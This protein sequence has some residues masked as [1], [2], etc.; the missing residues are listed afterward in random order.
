MERGADLSDIG[1]LITR[2]S[3]DRVQSTGKCLTVPFR[4]RI[5]SA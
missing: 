3:Y 2:D 4:S 5:F 1:Q